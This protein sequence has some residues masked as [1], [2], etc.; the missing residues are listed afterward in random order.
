[1]KIIYKSLSCK[2]CGSEDLIRFGSYHGVQRWW[3]KSCLHKFADNGSLP[4]M[5]VPINKVAISIGAYYEGRSLGTIPR[6]MHQLYGSFVA[7][8][9]VYYWINRF[10]KIAMIEADKAK[11]KNIGDTWIVDKKTIKI[12]G[13]RYWVIDVIDIDTRFLLTTQ[14]SDSHTVSDIKRVLESARDKAGK[15]PRQVLTDDWKGY[16]D[17]VEQAYGAESV[18]IRIKTLKGNVDIA[19][20]SE[21]SYNILKDRNKIIDRL[22]SKDHARLILEGWRIHYNYFRWQ[23][24]LNGKTPGEVAKSNFKYHSWPE[25]VHQA[26]LETLVN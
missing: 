19:K 20:L 9:S 15:V 10:L 18:N 16:S 8:S 11:I 25:L 4:H 24:A 13:K 14:L 1:M 7:K 17:G 2:L 23:T 12:G 5:K 3:C 21:Y 6:I 26:R 22:K